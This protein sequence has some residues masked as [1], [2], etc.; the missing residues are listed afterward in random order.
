[1]VGRGRPTTWPPRSPDLHR[2]DLYL[3]GTLKSLVYAAPVDN[4]EPLH[5][6]TVHACQTILNNPSVLEQ[7]RHSMTRRVEACL[8]SHGGHF[9]HLL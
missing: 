8:E 3:W 1:M 4:E 7:L 9:E 5:H 6:R 2:Q